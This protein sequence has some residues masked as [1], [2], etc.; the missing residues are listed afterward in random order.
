MTMK[1]K[2]ITTLVV[3]VVAQFFLNFSW[4]QTDSLHLLDE[5]LIVDTRAT[6]RT[7]LTVSN[8]DKEAIAARKG[9]TSMSYIVEQEPSIVSSGENGKIGNTSFRLRGIDATRINVNINGITLNEAESQMV[10]WVNI[11]NLAGMAQSMQLQRGIGSTNGGSAA[12]GGA[13]NIQTLNSPSTP[14]VQGELGLGAWN[15]RQFGIITGTGI[16]TKGWAADIAYNALLSDGYVRNGFCDHQSLFATLGHYGERSLLK[17]IFIMGK[18]HTGITW[19]GAMA[20]ELDQDPRYNGAGAYHDEAGNTYYYDNQSDNYNQ[21]HYQLFYSYAASERWML[22]AALDFTHGDGYYEEYQEV[23]SSKSKRKGT[24]DNGDYITQK[25]MDNNAYTISLSAHYTHKRL[26]LTFGE[27]LLHYHGKHFGEVIWRQQTSSKGGSRSFETTQRPEEW[28]RNNGIKNDATTFV[29]AN[30]AWNERISAYGDLQYRFVDYSILG[31]DEDLTAMDFHEQYHFF[32]PKMGI[33]FLPQGDKGKHKLFAVAG[34]S[35]R[36]PARADIKDAIKMHDTVKAE[37]MLDIELGY[38]FNNASGLTLD[39][40]GYAMLYKD[41]LTAS[42]RLSPS[43]Y[44]LMENVDKSY[45]IGLELSASWTPQLPHKCFSLSGNLTAS[46]N[47]IL[48]YCYHYTDYYGN[49]CT[50]S[51]GN[52]NL[53][54]SPSLV[55]ALTATGRIPI[56]YKKPLEIQLMVKYVGEMYC[57][58]TSRSETLQP[59]YFTLNG[60]ISH[61]WEIGERQSIRAELLLNNLLNNHY[62]LSAW[63]SDYYDMDGSCTIYR[64]FY[65]QP[66]FNLMFRIDFNL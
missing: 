10:Y 60:R 26:E 9:E 32:N 62:R 34:I 12:F 56:K 17:V 24:T 1:T 15:T 64:G 3:L 47:H 46:S 23:E 2:N 11:P 42:G 45:R 18:Q 8:L 48:D 13:L 51:M 5:V 41:Q 37:G 52:T 43:G 14:Y 31:P 7:P 58:N 6:D 57:D 40:N 22:K 49:T 54:Y 65:Q 39:L 20:E 35:H 61:K 33:T 28:Y 50:Q 38:G 25:K 21:R 36:E 59:S 19:D 30:Y 44:A 63:T 16:T 66:G 4:C 27:T 55:A 29:R 53:S